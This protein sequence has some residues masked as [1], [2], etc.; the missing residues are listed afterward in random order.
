M[1]EQISNAVKF[2]AF[3]TESKLGKTGLT[4]TVD[5]YGPGETLLVEAGSAVEIGGGLYRYILASGSTGDVGE[6]VCLFKTATDTVDLQHIPALWVVGR[7][8]VENLD[9]AISTRLSTA[10]YT[11]PTTPPTV[12]AIA[13]EVWDTVAADHDTAGTTGEALN[14]AGSASDPL[15]NAVPGSYASGTAGAALGRIG[16]GRISTV[17]PVAQNGDVTVV[18]GDDYSVSSGRA[19]SWTEEGG[20]WPTLTDAAEIWIAVAGDEFTVE[21]LAGSPTVIRAE[22]TEADTASIAT[23]VHPFTVKAELLNGDIIT[24]L[25]GM[26]T[27]L[28]G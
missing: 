9:A 27:Q 24:L 28:P 4:V 13:A 15:L 14:A 20:A 21:A 23:G 16:T 7:A 1:I 3:F 10:G 17:S 19:L 26:W 8:G 25:T 11:A 6:Y 18:Q 12:G 22:L 2:L 5:V